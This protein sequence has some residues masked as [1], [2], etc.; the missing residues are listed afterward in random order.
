MVKLLRFSGD[1]V[2]NDPNVLWD[3]LIKVNIFKKKIKIL[4]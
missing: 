1:K 3:V 4:F 2:I